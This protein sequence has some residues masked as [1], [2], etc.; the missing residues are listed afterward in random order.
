MEL[1]ITKYYNTGY[2]RCRAGD[3]GNSEILCGAVSEKTGDDFDKIGVLHP[4]EG[5]NLNAER[6]PFEAGFES[7]NRKL[8]K[9]DLPQIK[10][11]TQQ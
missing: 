7:R 9:H 5:E 10:R 3:G 6:A 8:G 2:G 11:Y 4:A 1:G